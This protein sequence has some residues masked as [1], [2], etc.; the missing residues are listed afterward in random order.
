[1]QTIRISPSTGILWWVFVFMWIEK[2]SVLY[3]LNFVS[4]FLVMHIAFAWQN[5]GFGFYRVC[6]TTLH[7]ILTPHLRVILCECCHVDSSNI[8]RRGDIVLFSLFICIVKTRVFTLWTSFSWLVFMQQRLFDKSWVVVARH[9]SPRMNA[10]CWDGF[11]GELVIMTVRI[12]LLLWRIWCCF[13]VFFRISRHASHV[14]R[15][16]LSW[17][18]IHRRCFW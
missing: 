3:S 16:R 14:R 2:T 4:C 7:L 18:F 6:S 10:P 9:P 1:M 12:S 15:I 11:V 8:L 5:H 17:V 13:F